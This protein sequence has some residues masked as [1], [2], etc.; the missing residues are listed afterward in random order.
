MT[1]SKPASAG[2]GRPL[3]AMTQ[4]V[5]S[6]PERGES[7]DCLDA[8]WAGFM[9]ACGFDLVP[10]PTRAADVETFLT[11]L[12][13]RGVV[14]SGGG[15]LAHL[16]PDDATPER[17]ALENRLIAYARDRKLPLAGVCR[18]MQMLCHVL[19]GGM[20]RVPGH[21][22][23]SH[24]LRPASPL[25]GHD[26]V[27]SFHEYGIAADALPRSLDVIA[28]SPDGLAE[29]FLSRDGL[30][31]GVMWHPERVAPFDENDIRLFR[32]FLS[33]RTRKAE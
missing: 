1:A 13:V 7:W 23:V 10:V 15:S 17:E 30:C 16:N 27:N 4:R 20:V 11:R 29:A 19:G 25:L 21:V 28:L 14:L 5:H 12:D 9:D 6:V 2:N 24:G 32:D 31:L 8:R 22:A 3:V 18:G 33:G 26:R